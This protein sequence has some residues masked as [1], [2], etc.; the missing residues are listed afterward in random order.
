MSELKQIRYEAERRDLIDRFIK[1]VEE[2][3]GHSLALAVERAKIDLTARPSA[4]IDMAPFGEAA[5][6][7]I[8]RADFDPRSGRRSGA[9]SARSRTC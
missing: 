8:E 1:L 6:I 4:S 3:R 5:P 7:S 2:R 9:S